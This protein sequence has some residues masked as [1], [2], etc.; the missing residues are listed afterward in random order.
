MDDN[1][2]CICLDNL[3]PITLKLKCKHSFHTECIVD[4]LKRDITCPM[5]R[6]NINLN[7]PFVAS[8]NI[9]FRSKILLVLND[10]TLTIFKNN[11]LTEI[12]LFHKIKTVKMGRL[13]S[14]NINLNTGFKKIYFYSLQDTNMF[15]KTLISKLQN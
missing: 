11:V 5:C 8:E 3:T 13:S 15:Y 9:I 14:V 12:I 1:I 4:W 6:Q 10:S 2:C 7:Y